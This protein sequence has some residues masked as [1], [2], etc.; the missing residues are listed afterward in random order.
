MNEGTESFEFKPTAFLSEDISFMNT[1]LGKEG[2]NGNWCYDT[3]CPTQIARLCE[4]A[5]KVSEGNLTGKHCK[6]TMEE[7]LI[8]IRFEELHG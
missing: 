2:F 5:K 3:K 7:P 1:I 6:V 4:Q 8:K